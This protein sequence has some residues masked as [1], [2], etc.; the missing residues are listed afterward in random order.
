MILLVSFLFCFFFSKMCQFIDLEL[1]I[2]EQFV[3][4]FEK[5]SSIDG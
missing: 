1:L 5:S 4:K 3:L 2:L